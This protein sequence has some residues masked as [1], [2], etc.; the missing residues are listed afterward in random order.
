MPSL[1]LLV[2][3]AEAEEFCALASKEKEKR[4]PMNFIA[5]LSFRVPIDNSKNKNKSVA[6]ALFESKACKKV[7]NSRQALGGHRASQKKLKGCF[8]TWLYH[9]LNDSQA[10]EY[11]ITHEEF[12]PTKSNSTLQFDQ[13]LDPPLMASTSKRKSKV[14][15][16]S[17]C[18]CIFSFG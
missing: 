7:F 18:H 14:H 13:G 16:C 4:N 3:E 1:T 11:V 15:E 6:K 9:R 5:P 17:I 8:A 10:N 2:A 12:F